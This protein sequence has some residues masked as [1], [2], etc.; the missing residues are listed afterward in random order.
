MTAATLMF[1]VA[2]LCAALATVIVVRR[3]ADE[4]AVYRNR[5]AGTMLGAAAI[6]L[7]GYAYA[8]RSWSAAS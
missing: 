2:A 6:I 4:A 3:A 1:M 5:I 7:S 8:L